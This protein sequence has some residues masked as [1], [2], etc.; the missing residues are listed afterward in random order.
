MKT[1]LTK[2]GLVAQYADVD[3]ARPKPVPVPKVVNT[4]AGIRYVMGRPAQFAHTDILKR[5]MRALTR[6]YGFMLSDD[7]ATTCVS[8]P[9]PPIWDV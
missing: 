2:L 7:D 1:N 4:I 8:L 3:G 5:D 9:S 6:G